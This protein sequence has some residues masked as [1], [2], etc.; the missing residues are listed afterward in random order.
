M[1][2]VER[3]LVLRRCADAV[4]LGEYWDWTCDEDFIDEWG[5]LQ[6][7]VACDL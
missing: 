1:G 7:T 3:D 6:P 5:P 4:C 2:P